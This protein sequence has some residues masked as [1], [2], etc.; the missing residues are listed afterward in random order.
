MKIL[1]II[2]ITMAFILLALLPIAAKV[3]TLMTFATIVS[4][5]ANAVMAYINFTR[6]K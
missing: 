2:N 5:L 6:S 1:A 3:G 4:I